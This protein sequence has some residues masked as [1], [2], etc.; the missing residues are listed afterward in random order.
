MQLDQ[1]QIKI[2]THD[3]RAV[4]LTFDNRS[5]TGTVIA[6]KHIN[7]PETECKR[8]MA[9]TPQL[10]KGHSREK[11]SDLVYLYIRR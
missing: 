6:S 2:Y 11:E 5:Y 1:D 3:M 4:K 9:G 7:Q 8:G 10:Q